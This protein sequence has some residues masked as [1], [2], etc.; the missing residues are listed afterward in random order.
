MTENQI[1]NLFVVEIMLGLNTQKENLD[2]H[3]G[4]ETIKDAPPSRD[5]SIGVVVEQAGSDEIIEEL[6]GLWS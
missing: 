4:L 5:D 1:E 6:V 3:T 2:R